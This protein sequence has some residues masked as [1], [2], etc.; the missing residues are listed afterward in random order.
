MNNIINFI[1]SEMNDGGK[2][3]SFLEEL[4]RGNDYEKRL[5][6]C[7]GIDLKNGLVDKDIM[8]KIFNNIDYDQCLQCSNGSSSLLTQYEEAVKVIQYFVSS[9]SDNSQK[10][11]FS[12]VMSASAFAYYYYKKIFKKPLIDYRRLK[13]QIE[14]GLLRDVNMTNEMRPEDYRKL[15]WVVP[16][17][18]ILSV[19][20]SLI[21]KGENLDD[22]LANEVVNRLGLIIN[23]DEYIYLEYEI[24]FNE[25]L[26]QP[27][28]LSKNWNE[29][30]FYI[31]YKNEDG[32]GRTR[33]R[34][35]D[36]SDLQMREKVHF[37]INDASKYKYNVEYLGVVNDTSYN[38]NN[39]ITESMQRYTL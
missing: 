32:F 24:G 12:R 22:K 38:T 18:D 23:G 9:V 26:Y 1:L 33:A 29:D 19:K 13:N 14:E 30:H 34:T 4:S 28:H 20:K 37:S 7:I 16:L 31:S 15:I 17:E 5:L 3:R 21:K 10:I 11:Q 27:S 36:D 6:I 39:L 2:A 35:G 25:M 8:T